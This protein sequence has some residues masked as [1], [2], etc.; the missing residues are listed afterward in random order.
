[1]IRQRV[2]VMA[3]AFCLAFSGTALFAQSETTDTIKSPE[4]T[5]AKP[6]GA[7]PAKTAGTTPPKVEM[8]DAEKA[9]AAAE[10]EKAQ[11][12]AYEKI[13]KEEIVTRIK[14]ILANKDEIMQTIPGLTKEKDAA[15]N[16]LYKFNGTKLEDLDKETAWKI[17]GRARNEASRINIDK[18]N[19]QLAQI[20]QIEAANKASRSAAQVRMY[21]Q[22]SRPP[23]TPPRTNTQVPS[24]PKTYKY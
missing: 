10:A 3:L 6:A 5:A 24:V 21:T 13:T 1:M 16:I 7:A 9:K 17:Y 12:A 15:G 14:D 8:T 22:P 2:V 4:A 20:K 18:L 19:R 11:K 23:S